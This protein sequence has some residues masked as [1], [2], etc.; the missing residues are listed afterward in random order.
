MLIRLVLLLTLSF[1]EQFSCRISNVMEFP[2][3]HCANIRLSDNSGAL[4]L[5]ARVCSTTAV[6]RLLR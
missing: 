3:T 1:D 4:Q 6:D 5:S 2:C